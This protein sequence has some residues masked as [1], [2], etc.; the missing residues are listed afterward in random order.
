MPVSICGYG[1]LCPLRQRGYILCD[2]MCRHCKVNDV[3][4][5]AADVCTKQGDI[6]LL[7]WRSTKYLPVQWSWRG[8]GF[9]KLVLVEEVRIM[10][11]CKCIN[12]YFWWLG[13]LVVG[14]VTSVDYWLEGPGFKPEF[15]VC[16]PCVRCICLRRYGWMEASAK[17]CK[18]KCII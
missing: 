14:M 4:G 8:L 7:V 11:K 18:R 5:T 13:G 3:W 2:F 16:R 9:C 1:L 15:C 12:D 6:K 10:Y 17:Y